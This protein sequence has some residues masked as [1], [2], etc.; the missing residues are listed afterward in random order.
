MTLPTQNVRLWAQVKFCLS[1]GTAVG[2]RTN[3]LVIGDLLDYGF[4]GNYLNQHQ[5]WY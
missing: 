2:H 4:R 3:L 5:L 1:S